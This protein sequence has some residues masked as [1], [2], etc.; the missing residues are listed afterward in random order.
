MLNN[1]IDHSGSDEIF[2]EMT[3]TAAMTSFRISDRG[4]GIF[5]KIKEALNLPEERMSI[6]E[7]SKGKLT[8]SPE[9][10][11]GL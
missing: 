2:V 10:H 3:H 9:L 5:R 8:T 4:I 7:L 11:T 1:A 6:L